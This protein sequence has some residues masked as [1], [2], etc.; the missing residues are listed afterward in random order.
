MVDS[1]S[2]HGV[3]S[4]Q[5]NALISKFDADGNGTITRAEWLQAFRKLMLDCP[6][7]VPLDDIV[8]RSLA[9]GQQTNTVCRDLRKPVGV[10]VGFVA[11]VSSL[12]SFETIVCPQQ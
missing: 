4:P 3:V 11:V 2:Q 10:G 8:K 5:F 6:R 9:P 7:G 1:E 12:T